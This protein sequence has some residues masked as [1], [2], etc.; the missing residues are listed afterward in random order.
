MWSQF[1]TDPVNTHRL[2]LTRAW[3]NWRGELATISA[4]GG[5]SRQARADFVND[6]IKPF[7]PE[8]QSILISI[9][10]LTAFY[11]R[12][13][14]CVDVGACDKRIIDAY[15]ETI[16]REFWGLYEHIIVEARR[17]HSKN[18]GTV[19]EAYIARK[20]EENKQ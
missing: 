4:V 5:G 12:T 14:L 10:E 18:L 7:N 9:Y 11:D 19:I 17:H 13:L 2:N 16:I 3:A 1:N 6:R 20:D 15:F 8:N